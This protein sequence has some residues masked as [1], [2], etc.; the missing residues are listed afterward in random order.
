[1]SDVLGWVWTSVYFCIAFGLALAAE[2]WLYNQFEPREGYSNTAA[3]VLSIAMLVA[4]L[5]FA[6]WMAVDPPRTSTSC[7]TLYDKQGA[8]SDC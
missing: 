4:A 7:P 1:M 2:I 5:G 3:G 6:T 8:H